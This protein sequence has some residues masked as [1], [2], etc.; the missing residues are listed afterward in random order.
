MRQDSTLSGSM[1]DA[2]NNLSSDIWGSGKFFSSDPDV[3]SAD[4]PLK[5]EPEILTEEEK[6][7]ESESLLK[8]LDTSEALQALLETADEWLFDAFELDRLSGGH[9][10]SVLSLHIMTRL[11][12]LDTFSIDKERFFA[13]MLEIERGYPDNAYHNRTHAAN[14]VQSMYIIMTRGLGPAFLGDHEMFASMLAAIVHDFQHKGVNNDFLVRFQD[15]LALKY[16]DKSPLENHHIAAAFQL[17]LSDK[18]RIFSNI[19]V[20]QFHK[21]RELM[22][23]MV[24]ATDMKLHFD[25]LGRFRLIES[26]LHQWDENLRKHERTLA[27]IATDSDH[28]QSP[29]NSATLEYSSEEESPSPSSEDITLSLQLAMK[30]ADIGHVYCSPDVHLKWVQKLEQEFF[31]QGDKEKELGAL[32][33]SPLMDREKAGITKSQRGFFQ[34]VVLPLF[35]SFGSAFPELYPAT[36][37]ICNNM[38]LWRKIEEDQLELSEVFDVKK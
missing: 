30:C 31:T 29:L 7:H 27:R 19:S 2:K 10:L 24:L 18:Y 3:M 28:D 38:E 16:N 32:Q 14:V 1:S 33:T 36:E 34:I 5:A 13:A 35:Q 21:I 37:S 9:P 23:E 8:I 4:K 6:R 20:D 25:I 22:I 15:D 17:L 12:L 26:K 11:N